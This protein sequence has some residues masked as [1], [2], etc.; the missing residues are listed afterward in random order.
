MARTHTYTRARA[1]LPTPA[2]ESVEELSIDSVLGL[3]ATINKARV[4]VPFLRGGN[5][6]SKIN[7]RFLISSPIGLKFCTPLD[8]DNTQ[9]RVGAN[10]EFPPQKNL[11][12]L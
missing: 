9:N 3:L 12:P 8:G 4:R 2:A 5:A 10:F 6:I 7:E 1:L 11:A